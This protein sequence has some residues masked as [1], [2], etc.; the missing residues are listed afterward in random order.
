MFRRGPAADE[1]IAARLGLVWHA[2]S[3]AFG[4]DRAVMAA[5][6]RFRVWCQALSARIDRAVIDGVVVGIARLAEWAG[7]RANAVQTGDG[8]LYAAFVG[9]GAVVLVSLA[10]WFAR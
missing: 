9:V 6:R 4:F 3:V 1:L 10:L 2:A 5:A 8:S 7:A